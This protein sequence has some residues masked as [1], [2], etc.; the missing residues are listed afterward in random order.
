MTQWHNW[1]QTDIAPHSSAADCALE[2]SLGWPEGTLAVLRA[3]FEHNLPRHVGWDCPPT[4]PFLCA[5]R[6]YKRGVAVR[7]QALPH[8]QVQTKLAWVAQLSELQFYFDQAD[9]M[10][11]DAQVAHLHPVC[12]EAVRDKLITVIA[13]EQEKN[14]ATVAS[15]RQQWLKHK[16]PRRWTIIG[17][18]IVLDVAALA[19]SMCGAEMVLL[20]TTLLAIIDAAHGGK[21]GVNFLPW[22]KNQL[23]TFYAAQQVVVCPAW[24]QTL[25]LAELQ[26]GAW[27]G[28]KHALLKGDMD[29]LRTWLHKMADAK[30]TWELSL[31][32]ATV[33][34]KLDIVARDF[35]EGGERRLLNF[36]HTLAHALE[37][38]AQ[39]NGK[40]LRHGSAVGV[41]ILYALLLSQ[42][43][44]KLQ[45]FP[46]LDALNDCP[47]MLT[48]AELEVALGFTDL[49]APRLWQRLQHYVAHD[50]KQRDT[51]R[52]ILW[53]GKSVA[54]EPQAV[55]ATVLHAVWQRLVGRLK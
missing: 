5:A 14:L 23:G 40:T 28:V 38:V 37:A 22:G 44:G 32:L 53:H 20:P 19:A 49:N 29:M 42:E 50:K 6:Y 54:S 48:R 10:V 11:C 25:P 3:A 21:N 1:Q 51:A 2:Q 55:S 13:S 15:I 36:G 8:S 31:L 33:Q 9:L 43:L 39:E 52:W 27:E 35:F 17:G 47:A 12:F 18:G 46:L 4:A 24:L 16:K 45:E 41:G 34:V 30:A 26:A 7:G